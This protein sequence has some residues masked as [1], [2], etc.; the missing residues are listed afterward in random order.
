MFLYYSYSSLKIIFSDNKTLNFIFS[1][2]IEFKPCRYE[3]HS[4]NDWEKTELDKNGV[5]IKLCYFAFDFDETWSKSDEK[6]QTFINNPF[7][8]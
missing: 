7:F 5:S 4:M 2:C 1:I 8:T 3:F 6:Y